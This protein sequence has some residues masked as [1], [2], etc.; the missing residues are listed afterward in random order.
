ML[1]LLLLSFFSISV[2]DI[3]SISGIAIDS[4]SSLTG[5]QA[6]ILFEE[7]FSWYDTRSTIV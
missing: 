7:S 4:S 6:V 5:V 1:L 3:D 2:V